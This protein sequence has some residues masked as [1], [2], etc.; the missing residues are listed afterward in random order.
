MYLMKEKQGGLIPTGL[1]RWPLKLIKH[2]ADTTCVTPSP[3]GS[4]ICICIYV[5]VVTLRW[6]SIYL[7]YWFLSFC[8]FHLA[9]SNSGHYSLS[10]KHSSL[11]PGKARF[12]GSLPTSPSQ[13]TGDESPIHFLKN[14]TY[15]LS[16]RN[17]GRC[18][19]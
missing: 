11:G 4:N 15:A 9:G 14:F 13:Y 8:S 17:P 7:L 6:H 18:Y 5:N 10:H 12:V 19:L 3:A 16:S 1:K 2:L